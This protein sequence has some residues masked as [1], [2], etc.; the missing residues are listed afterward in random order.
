[1]LNEQRVSG[2]GVH[3]TSLMVSMI[4]VYLVDSLTGASAG[5]IVVSAATSAANL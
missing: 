5:E 3:S 2:D 1:M 4:H